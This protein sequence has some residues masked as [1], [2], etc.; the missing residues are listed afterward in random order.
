MG[1]LSRNFSKYE[2]ACKC[3]CGFDDIAP[4]LIKVLQ[5]LRDKFGKPIYI[6]SGCRCPKH[7][8]EVGG[9]PDSQHTRGKASDIFWHGNVCPLYETLWE[10]YENGEVPEVGFIKLYPE[11]NFIHVDVRE[12]DAYFYKQRC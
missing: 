5:K 4:N 1:D 8:V 12:E 3:G 11:K 10:L 2:F 7:N 6:S 9:V